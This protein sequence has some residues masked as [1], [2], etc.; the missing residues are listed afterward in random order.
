MSFTIEHQIMN[1]LSERFRQHMVDNA[2]VLVPAGNETPVAAQNGVSISGSFSGAYPRSFN[3]SVLSA[4]ELTI[5]EN[6]LY[7]DLGTDA[8]APYNQVVSF[9]PGIPEPISGTGISIA[10]S[11][12][13]PIGTIYQLRMGN[14]SFTIAEVHEHPRDLNEMSV[15]SIA[16]Y[17][18]GNA[19]QNAP[20]ETMQSST[21]ITIALTVSPEQVENGD[22]FEMLG[23]IRDCINRDP[24]LWNNTTCLSSD[25]VYTGD[26]YFDQSDAGN[27]IFTASVQIVYRSKTKNA[28]LK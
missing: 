15:P 27:S 11:A 3:I 4:D 28:R 13:V 14:A 16:I 8:P 17:S 21:D 2:I 22:H 9:A 6:T 20:N 24:H 10:I 5:T 26:S 12:D 1:L 19:C 23:D 7:A 18:S 25:V